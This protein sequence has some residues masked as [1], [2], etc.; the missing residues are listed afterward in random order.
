MQLFVYLGETKHTIEVDRDTDT[1]AAVKAKIED[2]SDISVKSTHFL[3]KGTKLVDDV[4]TLKNYGIV[5]EDTLY[6]SEVSL[7]A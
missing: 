7:L 3:Y 6:I 5:K 4:I 2:K 1:L